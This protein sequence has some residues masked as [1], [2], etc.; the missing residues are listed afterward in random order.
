MR[1]AYLLVELVS[2]AGVVALDVRYRLF[3]AAGEV[4][5]GVVVVLVG[6]AFFVLWDVL[7]LVAGYYGRGEGSALLG[8]ELAPHFPLEELVF[9]T[10]LSYLTMIVHRAVTRALDARG[11]R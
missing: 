2:I 11:T 1:G 6:V 4:G 10:F 7:A 8:I 3:L 5:R 9:V